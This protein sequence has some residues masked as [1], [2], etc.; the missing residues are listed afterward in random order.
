MSTITCYLWNRC[1]LI[2]SKQLARISIQ[3]VFF[4]LIFSSKAAAYEAK[5]VFIVVIDG[6][7][8]T[9]AFADPMHQYIPHLWNDLRPRGI[10]C[11]HFFNLGQTTMTGALATITSGVNQYLPV[12]EGYDLKAAQE[13]PSIFEIYRKT[14]GITKDKVWLINGGGASTEYIGV[15]LHPKYGRKY[16]PRV[17]FDGN[18]A[19]DADTWNE[20]RR[21]MDTYHPSLVLAE[22]QGV[23]QAALTG[24]W[25]AYTEAIQSLDEIIYSFYV[26]LQ[27]DPYYAGST[28]LIITSS[29][30]RYGDEVGFHE[31]G[32]SSDSCRKLLFLAIGPDLKQNVI[33]SSPKT[34]LSIARTVGILLDFQVPMSEGGILLE[35]FQEPPPRF[36]EQQI[37]PTIAV[38]GD[39]VHL[40]YME[41][42]GA[43]WKIH[44]KRSPD[45]GSTWEE[46]VLVGDIGE[47][48]SEPAI[49]AHGSKVA[50]SWTSYVDNM[51]NVVARQS[52]DDGETWSEPLQFVEDS[53]AGINISP[54][55]A[56]DANRLV[57]VWSTASKKL[58]YRVIEGQT[59]VSSGTIPTGIEEAEAS[60]PLLSIYN[61][62]YY[63]AYKK[64]SALAP[65]YE[66]YLT[67]IV[68]GMWQP[69][70]RLTFDPNYSI[71]PS[72][73]V[74]EY[75]IHVVW[76]D[77]RD[78]HFEIYYKKSVDGTNWTSDQRLTFSG[79]GAWHPRLV[80]SSSEAMTLIWEDYREG[81][82]QTYMM[83]SLDGG[84]SWSDA[85]KVIAESGIS[86][87]PAAAES[88]EDIFC[89][90]Q[91]AVQQNWEIT[92]E[93]TA[94]MGKIDF[95]SSTLW[96]G[97]VDVKV[98]ENFAYCAY[99]NGL[100]VIDVSAEPVLISELYLEGRGSG[101]YVSGNHA[102]LA[103]GWGGLHII[104][105]S[106]P[107]NP[108]L[109]ATCATPGEAKDV[110]V[111][112]QHAF[113][114]DG[115]SG[116]QIVDISAPTAPQYVGS[117][118]TPGTAM[119][120]SVS[121]STA[122]VA[123]MASGLQVID[124]T[125]PE[126]PFITASHRVPGS[127]A[128]AV[129]V[130]GNLAYVAYGT[131][132]LI[133]V[134]VTNPYAPVGLGSLPTPSKAWDV[135][136][137]SPYAY[138]IDRD[139]G[140]QII[141][142]ANP[143]S[144]WL[145]G[146][147]DPPDWSYAVSLSGEY[148]YVADGWTGG[149][150]VIDISTPESPTLITEYYHIDEIHGIV[151]QNNHAY[152]TVSYG[153]W[154]LDVSDPLNPVYVSNI[155][156]P[157]YGFD[158]YVSGEYA[159]IAD[160]WAG[161]FV[162]DISDP[163][164]PSIVGNYSNIGVLR[165][166]QVSG[167]YAYLAYGTKGLVILNISNPSSPAFVGSY[168]TPDCAWGLCV[169]GPLVYVADGQS[170]LQIIDAATP[171]T[172][173]YVGSILIGNARNVSVEGSHAYVADKTTGLVVVNVTDPTE[174]FVEGFFSTSGYAN[175]VVA[176][177]GYVFLGDS[178]D[179]VLQISVDVPSEP[180]EVS[181]YHTPGNPLDLWLDS[182][183]IYV[184]DFASMI[185]LQT[186]S[187]P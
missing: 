85:A 19:S 158:S 167:D 91:E 65:N 169:D 156:L 44:Y 113:V 133:I 98:V 115:S 56:F 93:K 120:V 157:G 47:Q 186:V 164:V 41:N 87:R 73:T 61:G 132:G 84:L 128:F 145:V 94:P 174:P 123:D 23:H 4:L 36:Q 96:T 7:R 35:M 32:G 103:D 38:S 117:V 182:S 34:S 122:Y 129:D 126:S 6:I 9:E 18:G 53:E 176:Y 175:S 60:S 25:T 148:V 31:Y 184:A 114:A 139:F 22:F 81:M 3:I 178:V 149:L 66:V 181:R 144:P 45:Y 159:Y 48:S 30:G 183:E 55:L 8:N 179:G 59:V 33:L 40:A 110:M 39:F 92:V 67:A 155:D 150:Q 118:D 78:G 101:I 88:G 86:I 154:I 106:E 180:I 109:I 142:I 152:L 28:T 75:G 99:W 185:I 143:S 52:S 15:S 134:D 161:F 165:G 63:I 121:D 108:A 57:L 107:A 95:L 170:G 1:R 71:C 162:V 21:V 104:D 42:D 13:E 141:S 147:Y 130:S 26:K 2:L 187:S 153:V 97:L 131:N 160:G 105:I 166:V 163:H 102:Y 100:V 173:F 14:Q 16:C 136:V 10:I 51:W 124:I 82:A 80:T 119:G 43:N 27:S 83:K 171:E 172:P 54:C 17:S 74:N 24:S 5:N 72:M 111:S 77:N 29:F 49:A 89:A 116:L 70:V 11:D 138:L 127:G 50:I 68:E 12:K 125:N 168:D 137:S 79:T 112:G 58:A 90:W 69:R 151:V 146:S 76:A 64:Y 177:D 37:K 46:P 20:V 140:L 135:E 62:N